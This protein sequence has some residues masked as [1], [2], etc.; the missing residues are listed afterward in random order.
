VFYFTTELRERIHTS[1]IAADTLCCQHVGVMPVDTRQSLGTLLTA[2]GRA[3]RR[4]DCPINSHHHH[5]HHHYCTS[6]SNS[7]GLQS[8]P[9]TL[10]TQLTLLTVAH[11]PLAVSPYLATTHFVQLCLAFLTTT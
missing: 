10:P 6:S 9:D 11:H 3:S 1:L 4:D 8:F 5:H 2:R 7:I